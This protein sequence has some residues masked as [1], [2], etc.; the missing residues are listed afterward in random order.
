MSSIMTSPLPSAVTVEAHRRTRVQDPRSPLHRKNQEMSQLSRH[1]RAAETEAYQRIKEKWQNRALIQ[2]LR[3]QRHRRDSWH[4][5]SKEK[6]GP[7]GDGGYWMMGDEAE[8]GHHFLGSDIW[9]TSTLN[10]NETATGKFLCGDIVGRISRVNCTPIPDAFNPCTDVMGYEWLRVICWIVALTALL[11]NLIVLIVTLSSR[12]KIT[13]SKFLMCN[14]S[15]ADFLLGV[16]LLMLAAKDMSSQ[17]V[18]FSMSIPWQY[19]GGCQAAGFITIFGSQLSIY[20]LT[21]ITLERWYAISHAIH[22]T[23]RLRLRQASLIMIG[24]WLY[25]MIMAMLPLLGVSGYE[26]T[27]ICLPMRVKNVLDQGYVIALLVLNALAF[28]VIFACYLDM[29]CKVRGNNT[30]ARSNDATI[31]KRMAILVF[32]DF[33]CFFPIAFF[34]FTASIGHPLIDIT[35]SKILLV[36]FY[37]LNSCANPFLYA[38]FTK[39][40]KK[41]FFTLTSRHGFFTKQAQKW[42]GTGPHS[43][44]SHSQPLSSTSRN[45]SM[46]MQNFVHRPSD[47]SIL[48]QYTSIHRGSKPSLGFISPNHTPESVPKMFAKKMEKAPANFNVSTVSPGDSPVNC[49]RCNSHNPVERTK[50]GK[51]SCRLSVVQEFPYSQEDE[52]HEAGGKRANAAGQN[53]VDCEPPLEGC[54]SSTSGGGSAKNLPEEDDPTDENVSPHEEEEPLCHP[55]ACKARSASDYGATMPSGGNGRKQSMHSALTEVMYINDPSE[56]CALLEGPDAEHGDAALCGES[57]KDEW[58]MDNLENIFKDA[59]VET[60]LPACSCPEGEELTAA[61]IAIQK[62]H[63]NHYQSP[64]KGGAP[65]ESTE[66][67][68]CPHCHNTNTKKDDNEDESLASIKRRKKQ[69]YFTDKHSTDRDSGLSMN[70]GSIESDCSQLELLEKM[71]NHNSNDHAGRVLEEEEERLLPEPSCE[72][73]LMAEGSDSVLKLGQALPPQNLLSRSLGCLAE[74]TP[75]EDNRSR[76]FSCDRVCIWAWEFFFFFK[77]F[78]YLLLTCQMIFDY[79]EYIISVKGLIPHLSMRIFW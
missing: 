49:P 52:Q 72:G 1:R 15:S 29:F 13:V 78:L 23:K 31:A 51:E 63:S 71:A 2:R 24:G 64:P 37:P 32:T 30:T 8:T 25:A 35:N 55:G 42:R 26:T 58:E 6:D 5:S 34:A 17:G 46:A 44:Y 43:V 60:D 75:V 69:G 19:E 27:S 36:F 12:Q 48:T 67:N 45:N 40:F 68:V 47:G 76:T 38:V 56:D 61:D 39:Q 20:T 57:P 74:R 77:H 53:V 18:Y 54:E 73:Q 41:D 4:S 65:A 70:G 16:Y 14:L 59:V 11:G 62:D 21:V 66:S 7:Q 22:L 10:P 79:P 33:V 28:I 50:G 9:H 3:G